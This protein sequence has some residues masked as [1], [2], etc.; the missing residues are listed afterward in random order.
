MIDCPRCHTTNTSDSRY[1]RHCGQSLAKAEP[2]DPPR[3]SSEL[4]PIPDG[5]LAQTMPAWLRTPIASVGATASPP[6]QPASQQD[7]TPTATQAVPSE[8]GPI[9]PRTFLTEAD[10]PSWLRQLAAKKEPTASHPATEMP[11]DQTWL[12][13]PQCESASTAAS[14]STSTDSQQGPDM[15]SAPSTPA[16]E[17]GLERG[18]RNVPASG[19]TPSAGDQSSNDVPTKGSRALEPA[20]PRTSWPHLLLLLIVVIVVLAIGIVVILA[21]AGRL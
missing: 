10:L 2:V 5:G 11:W 9:D 7:V 15:G 14:R 8:P 1:C 12:A 13:L 4:P 3:Q 6:P 21:T 20:A 19:I 17:D 16:M 18:H